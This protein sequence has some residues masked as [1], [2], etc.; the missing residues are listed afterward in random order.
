MMDQR[1]G[2]RQS[3]LRADRA[4]ILDEAAETDRREAELYGRERGG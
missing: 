4:A 3:R 2:Q 1:V